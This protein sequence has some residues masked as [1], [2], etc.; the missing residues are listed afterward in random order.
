MISGKKILGRGIR[1]CAG[2]K[3]GRSLACWRNDST[4][5]RRLGRGGMGEHK[6]GRLGKVQVPQGLAGYSKHIGFCSK[7]EWK[8]LDG[9]G[10][11]S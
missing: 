11:C 9:L 10:F 8:A 1:K 3:G 6:S 5:A 4:V 2:N 7:S